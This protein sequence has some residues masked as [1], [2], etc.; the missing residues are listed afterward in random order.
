[1][2]TV[3]WKDLLIT[4]KRLF[5]PT[6]SQSFLYKLRIQIP[7]VLNR[8]WDTVTSVGIQYTEYFMPELTSFLWSIYTGSSNTNTQLAAVK[9]LLT[10]CI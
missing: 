10:C 6:F 5:K 2:C 8:K 1:M 9:I 3:L 4:L 7:L